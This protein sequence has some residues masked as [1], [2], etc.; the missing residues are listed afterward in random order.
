M[1][2][3]K[4]GENSTDPRRCTA[5]SS[6]TGK[7]CKK[8]VDSRWP[9]LPGSRWRSAARAE[10]GFWDDE[11][12]SRH[13]GRPEL[14]PIC[15]TVYSRIAMGRLCIGMA[16]CFRRLRFLFTFLLVGRGSSV[17]DSVLLSGSVNHATRAPLGEDQI[18]RSSC[19]IPSYRW[20]MTP[21]FT[22]SRT[23]CGMSGTIQPRIGEPAGW[24]VFAMAT[25][26]M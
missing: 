15:W 3:F 9:N 5:H 16:Y 23:A 25:G 21:R 11:G 12:R 19:G 14:D 24:G 2:S 18:P 10:A 4:G 17:N 7:R 26:G 8:C 20:K 13:D 1:A 22:R 6:Q